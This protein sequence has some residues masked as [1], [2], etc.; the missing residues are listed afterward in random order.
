MGRS[1]SKDLAH[2]TDEAAAAWLRQRD[3]VEN[4]SRILS[5]A[6]KLASRYSRDEILP[7]ARETYDARV[8]PLVGAGMELGR[9]LL[10]KPAPAVVARKSGLGTFVLDGLGVAAVAAVAYVAW[11]T[12]RTDDDAWVDDDFDVD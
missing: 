3:V 1:Y 9:H 12:L 7:R 8:A 5:D 4:A 11:Q 6:S 10:K 2:L